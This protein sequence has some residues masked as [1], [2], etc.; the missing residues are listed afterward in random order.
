MT[1]GTGGTDVDMFSFS[2]AAG[3]S[4]TADIDA[5]VNGSSLDSY[6][7]LFDSTGSKVA[8]NDDDG[9]GYG[10]DSF[11]T[12]TAPA[13]GTFS[14]GVSGSPNSAYDAMIGGGGVVGTT[15]S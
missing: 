2:L 11:L 10:G 6:L 3:Q 5:A 13:A 15:G 8:A 12:F 14:L 7:R 1:R 4:L 9:S